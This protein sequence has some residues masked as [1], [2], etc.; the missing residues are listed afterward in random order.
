MS[1]A[2]K[3]P[4][5]ISAGVVLNNTEYEAQGHWTSMDHIRFIDG[6]PEKIG[7][8]AQWNIPGTELT[9]TCRSVRCWQDFNYNIWHAFGTTARLWVYNQDKTRTNITPFI[10]TGTLANPFTTFIS[11]PTVNVTHALHGL[12]VGQY[13]NFS[14]ATALGGITIAGEYTVASV[15]DANTYTITHSSNATSNAGPG[16]GASV[17]YS[18]E[19]AY[20]N[21][22][23]STGGGWGLG[24]WGNGTWGTVHSSTTY[25]TLPRYWSLDQY[26]QYLLAMPSGGGLYQW[27]LNTSNRAAV[28][29]NAPA[30]GL[31]MFVTSERIVVVLGADGDFMLMKWSDDDDNTVWTPADANSANIRRLQE[32][33]RLIAGTRMA[34]GV[35]LV[36]SDTCVYLMQFTGTNNVYST[37]V[38]ATQCGLVG[39]AAFI[40]VDGIA[41][42]MTATGFKMYGG[43]L[44]DLPRWQEISPIFAAMD[45]N[46]KYKIHAHYNPS[47]RREIWWF[48]AATGSTEPNRY[49]MVNLDTWDWH[50]GTMSRTAFGLKSSLGDYTL[51]GVDTSGVIYEHELGLNADSLAL[52]WSL[53]SGYFDLDSGN[54]SLNIDGYVPDFNRQTGNIDVTITTK[55]LP[56]DSTPQ[57]TVTKSVAT[58]DSIIDMRSYGR[59]A[60]LKLS[61]T[62]VVG[63]DFALGAHRLE[64][65]GVPTKRQ[66]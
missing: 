8:W 18:Y 42:W 32:G 65:T 57:D 10:A 6:Q 17:A 5:P 47:I 55:D 27:Q 45:Q 60:K 66:K 62:G 20:G 11:S 43:Q 24:G 15:I 14:G 39:P 28:V 38:V 61:Q 52:D 26:G 7:G 31:Y 54:S 64:V 22:S 4:L 56:E 9:G 37:R 30:T 19:L 50:I 33:S 44:S 48:Y 59:Q 41:Y 1:E 12:L 29:T 2:R 46:Q 13:V 25:I 35:N 21:S 16:G 23:T 49:V 63:G 36:W 34:E 58:T 53:E 40:V 3:I 51:L